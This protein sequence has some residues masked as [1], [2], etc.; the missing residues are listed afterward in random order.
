MLKKL[1]LLITLGILSSSAIHAGFLSLRAYRNPLLRT[2]LVTLGDYHHSSASDPLERISTREGMPFF[3]DMLNRFH[4]DLYVEGTAELLETFKKLYPSALN[5]DSLEFKQ[6][7]L[8]KLLWVSKELSNNNIFLV[9]N[10]TESVR[11]INDLYTY[12]HQ[13]LSLFLKKIMEMLLHKSLNGQISVEVNAQFLKAINFP[14]T[15]LSK[16]SIDAFL[17]GDNLSSLRALFS[18]EQLYQLYIETLT[19]VVPSLTNSQKTIAILEQQIKEMQCEAVRAL[20]HAALVKDANA[21]C[22]WKPIKSNLDLIVSLITNIRETYNLNPHT[23]LA[24][25]IWNIAHQLKSIRAAFG[26]SIQQEPS[27]TNI[28]T[29]TLMYKMLIQEYSDFAF[30]THALK[31]QRA[32][33]YAGDLHCTAIDSLLTQQD[34]G[35]VKIF[36]KVSNNSDLTPQ[37][38]LKGLSQKDMRQFFEEVKTYFENNQHEYPTHQVL[39]T[40]EELQNFVSDDEDEEDEE[41]QDFDDVVSDKDIE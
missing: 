1:I 38:H 3:K 27:N 30:I 17:F 11:Y 26:Q 32:I 21:L 16:F 4:F 31:S 9:D 7:P 19:E 40:E 5:T 25:A 41:L 37:G 34:S 29:L 39:H 33:L 36:E 15:N 8:M 6:L 12:S 22:L 13:I 28:L 24:D 14:N 18:Q 35:F 23:S 10:R 20:V 2:F